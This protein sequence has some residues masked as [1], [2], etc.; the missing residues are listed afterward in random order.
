M[1]TKPEIGSP[2]SQTK[3]LQ[4]AVLQTNEDYLSNV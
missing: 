2:R 3:I 1:Q 4:V